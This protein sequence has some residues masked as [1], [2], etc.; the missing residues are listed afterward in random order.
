MAVLS[1]AALALAGCGG[2]GGGGGEST[3]A[4]P[5]D[6]LSVQISEGGSTFGVALD[7]AI[8]DRD[9]C[10]AVLTAIG[11][12]DEDATCAP[13]PDDGG[14]ITVTGTIDGKKIGSVLR[15]RT[16]CETTT[17]DDVAKVLG[18]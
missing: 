6:R 14:R 16:D 12:A 10:A 17:Y 3:A 5:P 13:T 9:A 15:R 8:A 4:T 2:G 1:A 7:C 18:F 11:R